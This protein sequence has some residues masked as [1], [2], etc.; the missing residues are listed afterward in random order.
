M[1]NKENIIKLFK[2]HLSGD[3]DST[4]QLEHIIHPSINTQYNKGI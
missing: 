3:S 1:N 4:Q 2:N